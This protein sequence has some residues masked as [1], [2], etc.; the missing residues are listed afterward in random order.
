MARMGRKEVHTELQRGNLLEND[1]FE[2][3][4]VARSGFEIGPS[5]PDLKWLSS[6]L[7]LLNLRVL[8]L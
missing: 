1:R 5:R 3:F 6:M 7:A 8:L 2:Y 4:R